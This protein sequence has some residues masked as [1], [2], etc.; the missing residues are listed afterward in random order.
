[1]ARKEVD[2]SP[3]RLGR[4]FNISKEAGELTLQYQT[5]ETQALETSRAFERCEEKLQMLDYVAL[6][7]D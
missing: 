4:K 2:S 6:K 3:L 1:M 7:G 5:K